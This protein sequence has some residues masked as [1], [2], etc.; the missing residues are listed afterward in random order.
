MRSN[1]DL[2]LRDISVYRLCLRKLNGANKVCKHKVCRKCRLNALSSIDK[3]GLTEVFPQRNNLL[4]IP[5]AITAS[6]GGSPPSAAAIYVR[7]TDVLVSWT[8]RG[9]L[10]N[11]RHRKSK[12]GLEWSP[13]TEYIV[14]GS[15]GSSEGE[16]VQGSSL[17]E[18]ATEFCCQYFSTSPGW[19]T[20]AA[21]PPQ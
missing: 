17:Q 3:C 14:P 8:G 11:Q 18:T 10:D 20:V 1:K 9:L 19:C 13:G 12:D 5:H 16:T 15:L 6:G 21:Q 2:V 4:L 7:Q